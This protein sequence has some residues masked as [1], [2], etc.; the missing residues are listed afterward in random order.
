MCEACW[1]Q[2]GQPRIETAAVMQCAELI[3]ELYT[4]CSVGGNLH[5]IVDDWNLD[6]DMFVGPLKKFM[7]ERHPRQLAIE[8]ELYSMLRGMTEMERASAI[9]RGLRFT[10]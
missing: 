9:A 4:Y 3:G 6:D 1:D 2:M 8:E 7:G 5:C 10:A